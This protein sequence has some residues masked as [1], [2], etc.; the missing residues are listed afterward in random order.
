MEKDEKGPVQEAALPPCP[1][2]HCSAE[3][4]GFSS[5]DTDSRSD[6]MAEPQV[7]QRV[8]FF[9]IPCSEVAVVV[10]FLFLN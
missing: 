3:L 6:G 2:S 9:P 8:P 5:P 4:H 1:R 7:S 10:S